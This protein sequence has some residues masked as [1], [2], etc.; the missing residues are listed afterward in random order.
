MVHEQMFQLWQGNM[1]YKNPNVVFMM[2]SHRFWFIDLT[3][4][5]AYLLMLLVMLVS[6]IWVFN[7]SL[8]IAELDNRLEWHHVTFKI[9][10]ISPLKQLLLKRS[11]NF[12]QF[13]THTITSLTLRYWL[14]KS[15]LYTCCVHYQDH[16][17]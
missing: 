8:Q 11:W 1:H 13:S 6:H 3:A 15:W 2:R 5:N 10:L 12:N 7:G 17:G 4:L 9:Q 14:K 16:F